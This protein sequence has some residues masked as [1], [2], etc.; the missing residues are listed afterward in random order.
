M[1]QFLCSW[2]FLH[3]HE[4]WNVEISCCLILKETILTRC[5]FH[6]VATSILVVWILSSKMKFDSTKMTPGADSQNSSLARMVRNRSDLVSGSQWRQRK[7]DSRQD[8]IQS[9]IVLLSPHFCVYGPIVALPCT[10]F[11]YK[12]VKITFQS[13]LR[14][15]NI[16]KSMIGWVTRL[17]SHYPHFETAS[18][19]Q[20]GI[21]K[22]ESRNFA[23]KISLKF[24]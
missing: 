21:L 24:C 12:Q 18:G 20:N 17:G 16:E 14:T 4:N 10:A 9:W 13:V 11:F 2:L 6:L 15:K 1:I 5:N 8:T 7:R 3:C 22:T 19:L 23:A